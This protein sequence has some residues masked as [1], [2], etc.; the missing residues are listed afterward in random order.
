MARRFFMALV[1]IGLFAAGV[2]V[3]ASW[4]WRNLSPINDALVQQFTV[5]AA[6][7]YA[8]TQ[9]FLGNDRVAEEA[10]HKYLDLMEQMHNEQKLTGPSYGFDTTVALVRLGNVRLRAGDPQGAQQF[11]D[12]AVK[13]CTETGWK[14]ECSEKRVREVVDMVDKSSLAYQL[15]HLPEGSPTSSP[16]SHSESDAEQTPGG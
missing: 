11:L 8:S 2:V 13:Q 7:V 5:S 14:D 9:Y 1:A 3:G 16:S 10:L 4:G 12:Q 15:V 6:G